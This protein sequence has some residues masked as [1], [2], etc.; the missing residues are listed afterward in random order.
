MSDPRCASA[1]ESESERERERRRAC[2]GKG[3]G[4]GRRQPGR[5]PGRQARAHQ[6]TTTFPCPCQPSPGRAHPK[7]QRHPPVAPSRALALRPM[8]EVGRHR[9]SAAEAGAASSR[10]LKVGRCAAPVPCARARLYKYMRAAVCRPVSRR[11]RTSVPLSARTASNGLVA[12]RGLECCS[13]RQRLDK[14]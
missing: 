14:R 3:R 12:L 1:R 6:L 4:G 11:P 7:R 13:S 2:L 5:Q 8:V 9:P 10:P